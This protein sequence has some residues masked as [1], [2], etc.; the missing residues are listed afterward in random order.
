MQGCHKY[1][2]WEKQHDLI[3]A[4]CVIWDEEIGGGKTVF[5]FIYIW[6][7]LDD[8]YKFFFGD[9]VHPM[10]KVGLCYVSC[11]NLGMSLQIKLIVVH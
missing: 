10:P 9:F 11:L 5:K 4:Q 8:S 3:S 1:E 6:I 2:T 7:S